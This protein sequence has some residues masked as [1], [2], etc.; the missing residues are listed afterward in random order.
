MT[1]DVSETAAWLSTLDAWKTREERME[2]VTTPEEEDARERRWHSFIA[3][4][5]EFAASERDGYAAVLRAVSEA[6]KAQRE[7]FGG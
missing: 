6:M 2:S 5:R 1:L 3:E 4:C 7:L